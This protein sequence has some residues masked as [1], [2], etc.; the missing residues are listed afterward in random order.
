M[1]SF[2][3][4][5]SRL[6]LVG[7]NARL[8]GGT[9]KI[10]EDLGVAYDLVA[11]T[12]QALER[13]AE[14][15]YRFLIAPGREGIELCEKL[16][17]QDGRQPYVLI[18]A[19][20][21][22]QTFQIAADRAG[23]DD[24]VVLPLT[25]EKLGARIRLATRILSGQDREIRYLTE[26]NESLRHAS[27]RFEDLFSGLPVACFT[28]DLEGNVYEWN[29]AAEEAFGIAAFDTLM[30]PVWEVFRK[31]EED[32]T[33]DRC[34]SILSDS[35]A[36]EF[37]W[38][39]CSEG[40]VRIFACRAIVLRDAK[41]NPVG[42][43]CANVDITARKRV[44]SILTSEKANLES[45][46][47]RLL[48]LASRDV[49]TGLSNR[50]SFLNELDGA[51]AAYQTTGKPFSLVL[52]D[53]DNFKSYNDSFGHP[54]GDE[55]LRRF[56]RILRSTARSSEQPA[57][58]GGE[59]FAIVLHG[60]NEESGTLAANRFRK[61]VE[62]GDWIERDVTCSLGVATI[63]VNGKTAKEMIA[64]ADAALYA[65][66]L[67]GRNRTTHAPIYSDGAMAA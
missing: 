12:H 38:T 28:F 23:V 62:E 24:L 61:A 48:D 47:A 14:T 64:A 6:L 67:H 15:P 46:N 33:H 19:P 2:L 55:V 35:L 3:S 7:G 9:Q 29:R 43:V 40:F 32:W 37:D 10:L 51:I 21:E 63:G 4:L 11:T 20:T 59:E 49:L 66:K 39:F 31:G 13:H 16:R 1:S 52:V 26:L 25:R 65:S 58:Y 50:R 5:P 56:A 60:T 27:R 44:E 18:V 53:I 57:R 41:G 34:A 36:E 42:A 17:I 54:A 22:D 30:R 8:A 45:A